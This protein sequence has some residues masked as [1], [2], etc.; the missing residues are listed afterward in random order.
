M[1]PHPANGSPARSSQHTAAPNELRCARYK[2]SGRDDRQSRQVVSHAL[3][4]APDSFCIEHPTR[5][6]AKL[7]CRRLQRLWFEGLAMAT[8][9]ST[10]HPDDAR[11]GSTQDHPGG[12]GPDAGGWASRAPRGPLERRQ[13]SSFDHGGNLILGTRGPYLLGLAHAAWI[14]RMASICGRL[15]AAMPAELDLK[16]FISASESTCDD[17]GMAAD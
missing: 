5:H 15:I 4:A 7:R 12:G 13:L 16:V 10:N 2:L 1:A 8:S 9:A 14:F 3:G 6:P 11:D 17:C